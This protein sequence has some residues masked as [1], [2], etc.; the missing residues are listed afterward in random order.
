MSEFSIRSEVGKTSGRY[1]LNVNGTEAVLNYRIASAERRIAYHTGAPVSLRGQGVGH[2]LVAQMVEDARRE[3][4]RIVP[5]C[6]FVEAERRKHPEW[7]E[8]FAE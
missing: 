7:A 5:D 6:S 4:F 1:V 3:G 8:A 2:A